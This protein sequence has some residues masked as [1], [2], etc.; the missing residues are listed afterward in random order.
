MPLALRDKYSIVN[1]AGENTS[2]CL[3]GAYRRRPAGPA[4]RVA[5]AKMPGSRQLWFSPHRAARWSPEWNWNDDPRR[6]EPPKS[7]VREKP[8]K[9]LTLC[10]FPGRFGDDLR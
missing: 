1:S 8:L 9:M 3:G 7:E 4:A 10:E 6:K 5:P 2:E